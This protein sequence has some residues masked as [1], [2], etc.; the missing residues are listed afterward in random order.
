MDFALSSS[1]GPLK[2]VQIIMGISGLIFF[3]SAASSTPVICGMASFLQQP[4]LFIPQTTIF[5]IKILKQT[6]VCGVWD[7]EF[8]VT[9]A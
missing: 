1:M 5:M 4:P 7:H 9:N 8:Q 6:V 2:P 3:N